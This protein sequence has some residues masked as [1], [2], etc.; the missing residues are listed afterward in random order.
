M[1]AVGSRSS[2]ERPY[3]QP[4][5]QDI[6]NPA[7]QWNWFQA[8]LSHIDLGDELYLDMTHGVPIVLSAA[9]TYLQAV[10]NV[11]L[12]A[13][14]HA[15]D[16]VPGC[17]VVDFKDCYAI[18][19]WAD[20]VELESDGGAGAPPRREGAGR[21]P[22]RFRPRLDLRL[23]RRSPVRGPAAGHSRDRPGREWAPGRGEPRLR[24]TI[25]CPDPIRACVFQRSAISSPPRSS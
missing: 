24:V 19:Q 13:V 21:R 22:Q 11:E 17:P 8:L 4:I 2:P 25:S 12:C 9:L 20:A 5:S 16:Q 10:E 15:A 7:E 1:S 3:V 14:Y 6:A 18:G 23:A